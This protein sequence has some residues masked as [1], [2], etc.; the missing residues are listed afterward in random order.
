[1]QKGEPL[2]ARDRAGGCERVSHLATERRIGEEW[3][4]RN[5]LLVSCIVARGMNYY[6]NS[7]LRLYMV[8]SWV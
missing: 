1:M 8:P 3:L 6:G 2:N 5:K 4:E 7:V